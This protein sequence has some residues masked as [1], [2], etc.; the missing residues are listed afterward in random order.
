M[1]K[2]VTYKRFLRK[3]VCFKLLNEERFFHN[4]L[5]FTGITVERS[6]GKIIE[7]R[8]VAGILDGLR[9][10]EFFIDNRVHF[11]F[12]LGGTEHGYDLLVIKQD[13]RK[14][15]SWRGF[16]LLDTGQTIE[17]LHIP[18]N[19]SVQY[20]NLLDE[21]TPLD[22][23]RINDKIQWQLRRKDFMEEGYYDGE[24][25]LLPYFIKQEQIKRQVSQADEL[26]EVKFVAGADVAYNE[27]EQRMVGALVVLD[28]RTLEL[29]DQA[30]HEMDITFPYMPG[31]FSFREVPP[32]VEAYRKLKVRPDLIVCD[33]HGVA[34]PKGA[35][36][37]SHL[38]I[39][40]DVP[41][42]GCAKSRLIGGYDELGSTRGSYAALMLGEKEIGRALRTQDDIKP[43]FV[44]VGHRVSLDTACE[45]VLK[46]CPE[47]RQPETTRKAD[48]LVRTVMKERTDLGFPEE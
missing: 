10:T 3:S 46:L 34:H 45:W 30:I 31:L 16:S 19:G 1:I 48:A 5:P 22:K 37:A 28:A 42:I 21:D 14:S 17:F 29:V 8:Y 23:I 26:A 4:G 33:G 12:F 41:T 32:L 43:M 7:Q 40:L 38:G 11:E 27:L 2:L 35:G 25:D 13:N 6:A 9:R 15:G 39:E 20:F 18:A 47:Y 44:S 36:M 24:E